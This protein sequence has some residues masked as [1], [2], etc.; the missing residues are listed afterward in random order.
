MEIGVD[1]NIYNTGGSK[2][3]GKKAPLTNSKSRKYVKP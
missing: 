1:E 3:G 2:R